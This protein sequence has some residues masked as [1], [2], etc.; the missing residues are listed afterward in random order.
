MTYSFVVFC[1]SWWA[2]SSW[3]F[4]EKWKLLDGDNGIAFMFVFVVVAFIPFFWL[5]WLRHESYKSKHG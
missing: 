2:L 3:L 4:F 5:W 1:L